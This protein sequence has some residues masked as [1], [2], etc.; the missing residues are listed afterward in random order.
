MTGTR[1]ASCKD[2]ENYGHTAEGF[3][4]VRVHRNKIKSIYCK[5]NLKEKE[6]DRQT[7]LSLSPTPNPKGKMGKITTATK[8]VNIQ[9]IFSTL[10][11]TISLIGIV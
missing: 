8:S 1:P 5:F 9:S 7:S 11:Q 2:L 3:Y 10:P 6:K 4:I